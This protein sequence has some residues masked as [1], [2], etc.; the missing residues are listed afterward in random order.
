MCNSSFEGMG[1][2]VNL[3]KQLCTALI[4][5]LLVGVL[6]GGGGQLDKYHKLL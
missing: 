3:S 2:G 1:E 4:A 6:K 5:S